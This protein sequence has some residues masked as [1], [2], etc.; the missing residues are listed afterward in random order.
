MQVLWN[1]SAADEESQAADSLATA[2]TILDAAEISLPTGSLANGAY[3][4]LGNYYSLPEWIVS[5]PKNISSEEDHGDDEDTTV[6]G[7]DIDNDANND[8]SGKPGKGK[9]FDEPAEEVQIMARLSETGKD[10]TVTID[11]TDSVRNVV[12]KVAETCSLGP[13]KKIRLA[14]MGKMLRESNTLDA[15]GWIPG[16]IINA[17]VFEQ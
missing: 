5:D 12:R 17:L 4:A 13:G 8:D 3:D 16:H 9:A 6:S 7:N 10:I 2:Q 15:Q 14:Y 11:K 1:T